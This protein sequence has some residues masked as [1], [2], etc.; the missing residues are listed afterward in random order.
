MAIYWLEIRGLNRAT[1]SR[2]HSIMS[3]ISILLA[4]LLEQARPLP[5]G[6]PVH[7]AA[8]E[9]LRWVGR[10]FDT[11]ANRHTALAWALSVLFPA[12]VT[13]AVHWALL[14]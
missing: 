9:W 1:V 6:N 10:N 4:L 7:G 2:Y 12:L 11:G 3:F 13:L 8:R 14:W 5:Q